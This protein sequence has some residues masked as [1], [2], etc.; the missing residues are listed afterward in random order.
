ME[1]AV[2]KHAE[3]AKYAAPLAEATAKIAGYQ[4]AKTK[5]VEDANTQLIA[6]AD[7]EHDREAELDA[8]AARW[9]PRSR[10]SSRSWPPRARSWPTRPPATP[11][12]LFCRPTWP[13]RALNGIASP[14][15]SRPRRRATLNSSAAGRTSTTKRTKLCR[16][17][18]PPGA[19]RPGARRVARPP[20]G[21][22]Q[23]RPAGPRD[24]RRGPDDHRDDERPAH[25]LLQHAVHLELVTQVEK[26]D[27]SGMRDEFTVRCSTT[28]PAATG[29]TSRSSRAARRSSSR[30]P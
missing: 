12:R 24:R 16:R 27:K 25:Q 20:E 7:R 4:D 6:V 10:R 19:G 22:R 13:R 18:P 30:K 5:A 23:G 1:A 17:P 21:A 11:R 15:R 2:A 28:R 3:Y 26:A 9:T 29:A 8:Q 14:A